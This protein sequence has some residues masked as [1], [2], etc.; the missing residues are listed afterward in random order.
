[1]QEHTLKPYE[2]ELT[3]L[4]ERVLRMGAMV[5]RMITDASHSLLERDLGLASR[6]IPY[7]HAI[8]AAEVD[9]DELCTRI[10]ALY[11]PVA[12]DLRFITSAIKIA[13]E[14]ERMSDQAVNICERVLEQN[15]DTPPCA[16]NFRLAEMS[17][18]AST[19]LQDAMT[20]FEQRD[21]ELAQRVCGQDETMDQYHASSYQQLIELMA[22]EPQHAVN[23]IRLLFISKYLER[24]ADHASNIAEML[25]YL[26]KG[27]SIRNL[28]DTDRPPA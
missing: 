20:A 2:N 6:L 14:L 28:S 22:N 1:M 5:Y 26:V 17:Q 16:S 9:I 13:T 18:L 11:Q 3:E 23:A 7:D 25:I 12:V 8:N 15:M 10:L 21:T 4:A 27:R 19:M 24:I